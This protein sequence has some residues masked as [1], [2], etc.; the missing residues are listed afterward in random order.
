MKMK[1]IMM[2]AAFTLCAS[3]ASAQELALPHKVENVEILDLDGKPAMLPHWGEKN[4]MIFYIDPDKHKQ[5]HDF[6]VELEETGRAAGENIYGFGIMN[7]K[8]APMV[9]NGMARNMAKK[10][11]ATNGALVMADQD[12]IVSTKWGL[13]DCNNKFVLLIV[14][15]EGEL[16][17]MRKGVLSDQDKEDF[18]AT[19]DKYK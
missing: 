5:N 2:L 19:I 17:F 1:V 11:T 13:G 6:T 14:S 3:A 10:R 12:R 18:Y 16:V 9:P 15:K 7:L 4:L 8:D